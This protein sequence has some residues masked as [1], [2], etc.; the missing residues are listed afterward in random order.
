MLCVESCLCT[1][2]VGGCL[3]CESLLSLLLLSRA[4]LLC[5]FGLLS[6]SRHVCVWWTG[7]VRWMCAWLVLRRVREFWVCA[8]VL[9][10]PVACSVRVSVLEG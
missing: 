2:F 1:P 3:V 5:V 8:F 7:G 9:C 4:R 6:C 10:V